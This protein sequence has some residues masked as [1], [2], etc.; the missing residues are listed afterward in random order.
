MGYFV[1]DSMW[2]PL[3]ASP[4]ECVDISSFHFITH[5]LRHWHPRGLAGWAVDRLAEQGVPVDGTEG[6]G[7]DARFLATGLKDVCVDDVRAAWASLQPGG[8]SARHITIIGCGTLEAEPT[9]PLLEKGAGGLFVDG[10]PKLIR[11]LRRSRWVAPH[12]VILNSTV[13]P[14]N[15]LRL[16]AAHPQVVELMEV[17]QVDIDTLDGPVVMRI[18]DVARPQAVVVEVRNFVPFPLRYAFLEP[19]TDG[20]SWGGATLNYWIYELRL[21]GYELAKMDVLDAIFVRR[22]AD[23]LPSERRKRWLGVLACY[24]RNLLREPSPAFFLRAWPDSTDAGDWASAGASEAE[25]WLRLK[26]AWME[27]PPSEAVGDIWRNLTARRGD[28]RFSLDV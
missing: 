19:D 12:R 1:Y 16:L 11:G 22:P 23:A 7:E 9:Q 14:A 20:L 24:L 8:F 28:L 5:P 21:R 25:Q 3:E 13:T 26:H 27:A 2:Y 15:V 4:E 17:L 10:N 18:L 6:R